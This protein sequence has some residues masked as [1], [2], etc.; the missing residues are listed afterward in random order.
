[1]TSIVAA[2]L[3]LAATCAQAG[4]TVK[5]TGYTFGSAKSVN[6]KI[7]YAGSNPLDKSYSGGAGQFT[8]TLNGNSFTTYC[9]DLYETFHFNHTYTN[10]NIVAL[11]TAKAFDIGRLMTQWGSN[12]DTATKSAAFQVALW[13]IM[14][15]TGS[16]YRLSNPSQGIFSETA[17][18]NGVRALAQSYLDDLGSVSNFQVSMLQSLGHYN[19]DH[20]WVAG[21]Q[22]FLI[23]TP[24]PEPSTY[25]L[26]LAGLAG[27]GFVARRRARRA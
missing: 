16:L 14:Y 4:E 12:V 5:L 6:V 11:D 9:L 21:N 17:S 3:M 20:R 24:V 25:A 10:Y 7:D 2:G 15:D 23:T 1:M 22:D 19:G 8:G 13:E 18:N 27:V 26:M